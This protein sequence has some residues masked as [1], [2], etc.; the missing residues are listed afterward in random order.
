M[1]LKFLDVA[2]YTAKLK[3]VKSTSIMTRAEKFHEEGLFSEEIFGREKSPERKTT[4][5]YIELNAKVIHPAALMMLYRLDR[6]IKKFLS[7]ESTF[8]V[9]ENG[10][11]IEDPEGVTGID[12]F[13][14]MF[15]KIKFTPSE[16]SK[17]F[18]EVLEKSYNDNVLFIDRIPVIP[19]IFRDVTKDTKTGEIKI[20]P[21]NDYYLTIL[22]RSFSI[23]AVGSPGPLLDIL[24]YGIQEAVVDLD[25]F[26]KTKLSKKFGLIRSQ[27]LGKRIE[28]SSR[29][30]IANGPELKVNEVGLPFRMAIVLFEPFIIH[31]LLYT[32]IFDK[33]VLSKAV[34]DLTGQELSVESIKN[35]IKIIED[36]D[37]IPEEIDKI[38]YQAAE[39]AMKGRLVLAKRDPVLIPES[40]RAF[41]PVLIR[42]NVMR[43]NNFQVAGFNADFD[44]DQMAVFHPLSDKAQEDAHRLLRGQTGENSTSISFGLNKESFLGLF[45]LTKDYKLKGKPKEI[46]V[47]DMSNIYDPSTP[48]LYKNKVIPVGKVIF[49]NALPKGF[50]FIDTTVTKKVANAIVSEIYN[51]FG[52]EEAKSCIFRLQTIGYKY[53]TL[54]GSSIT[55]DMF[56]IPESI[57]K[58][59]KNIVNM[60]P[61]EAVKTIELMRKLMIEHLKDTG[62]YDLCES[63]STKGWDQPTQ[64]L[65]AKGVISDVQGNLLPPIKGSFAEGLSPTEHFKSSLGARK[66][67]VDRVVNTSDTGYT[68]RQLAYLLNG[69]ELDLLL[70]D[71]KTKR[72]LTLK[73]TDDM[74]KRLTG[75]FIVEDGKVIEFDPSKYN[76]GDTINLRSPIYCKSLKICHTC[77]GKLL[78][79]H[80]TPYIGVLASQIIG[81]RGTQ[82]IMR[83]SSGLVHFNGNLVP[84]EDLFEMGKDYIKD[85]DVETVRF[86]NVIFGKN[87]EVNA[88]QIQKHPAHD[89][90]LFITTQSGASMICQ[91]NH[92][93]LK[94]KHPIHTKYDNKHCRLIGDNIYTE[95]MSTRKPFK[96]DNDELEIVEAKNIKKYDALWLDNSMA[97]ES[98][99]DIIPE[100]NGYITGIYC[101][102]GCKIWEDR[103]IKGN[104]I[105]QNTEGIIKE[106]IFLEATNQFEKATKTKQGI[107]IWDNNRQLNKIILGDYAWEKRLR[108]DFINFSKEW[109]LDFLAGLIDGDGTVFTNSST[110]CRIYTT[111]YYLMQQLYAICIKLGFKFN[112]CKAQYSEKYNRT[113]LSFNCDIR[114]YDENVNINSEKLKSNGKIIP[115][116]IRKEKIIRGFD[117][118]T[119]IKEIE[120]WDY[121]VY[122][123]KTD[124][125]E[126]L[127]SCLQTHNSFHTGGAIKLKTRDVIGEFAEN[128]PY[129][130]KGVISSIFKQ[131]QDKIITKKSGNLIL[132][133]S[134]YTIG[135][136]LLINEDDGTIWLK[137]LLAIY[138]TEDKKI[139][140]ILDAPVIVQIKSDL[141][142]E[143][144]HRIVLSYEAN[145]EIFEI[146]IEKEELKELVLYMRRLIG[147]RE[148]FKDTT[149][150]FMKLFRIYGGDIS[151]MDL[152]HLEVLVS[153]CLRDKDRPILPARVG[154][155]PDDPAM[156][157]LKKNVFS[158]SFL[159][160]LSFENIGEAIRAGLTS[161]YELEP[162]ILEKVLQG[163]LVS[164]PEKK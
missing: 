133:L 140:V 35:V 27:L 68:S 86:D 82:L 34:N 152:V 110:C 73:L 113:R 156:F 160:G 30:V 158:T 40:V 119:T 121:P 12:A 107:N 15:P 150:L 56:D 141:I 53:S 11:L 37:V 23:K 31:I 75:R 96:T 99:N 80:K 157:N 69:V 26:I 10:N 5:G 62:L 63:G 103:K 59:K 123:I 1:L 105:T 78:L 153:Q 90:M 100:L 47:E 83:C 144:K 126:Y 66:G 74:I 118:I 145:E 14:E 136:D 65:I 70:N 91:S 45:L 138:E 25:D 18:V 49:N 127:L 111:S 104:H 116:K 155:N 51:K 164:E 41:Y 61:E 154:K 85:G 88:I 148:I 3:Q 32:D 43:L 2:H 50:R 64:M 28:F 112:V 106:R 79:R 120:R 55:L 131:E 98:K 137:S 29:A 4:F 9:D 46:S 22:K 38:F 39:M 151:N 17:K 109:L 95:Y 71:C 146:P 33:E 13:I 8:N 44:G 77:Y 134:D 84:F 19:P 42:D 94:K 143:K 36:N 16:V 114:F 162:S 7:A 130:T 52:E 72:T 135:S 76:S 159:Q 20:D 67:I 128:D 102:E 48:V 108:F 132:S 24:T 115:I 89:K 54:V 93:L 147:G 57:L 117:K 81:E 161:E 142:H 125:E 87:G 6:R 21:L 101:A 58:L 124:T 149:H 97:L 129:I 92:P 122:D 60:T 139:N 163:T